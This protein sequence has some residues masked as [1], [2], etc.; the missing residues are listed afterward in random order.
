MPDFDLIAWAGLFGP[1]KL[2]P[3]ILNT[4]SS[5]LGN[6]LADP[7]VQQRLAATGVETVYQPHDVF[8]KYLEV[9]LIKW[10]TLIKASGIEPQ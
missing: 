6:V 3:D 7:N 9:E 1:A 10:T 2:P 8:T 4:L 5:E